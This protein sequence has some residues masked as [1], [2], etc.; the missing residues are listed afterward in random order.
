MYKDG[1]DRACAKPVTVTRH[2][3]PYCTIHDPEMVT[4]R[5]L[6][7]TERRDA[8]IKQHNDER[9]KKAAFERIAEEA[10]RAVEDGNAIGPL[11]AAVKA[12]KELP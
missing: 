9:A 10:V 7:R 5:A 3:K 4:A 12:W 6:A 1:R 11:V 8:E 2:G